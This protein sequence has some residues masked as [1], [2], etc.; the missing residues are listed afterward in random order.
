MGKDRA[1]SADDAGG[2]WPLFSRRLENREF[3]LFSFAP[4]VLTFVIRGG[5]KSAPRPSATRTH[6]GFGGTAD[7]SLLSYHIS[8]KKYEK[9]AKNIQKNKS[10]GPPPAV[11]I[12]YDE[13]QNERRK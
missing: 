1:P 12:L 8:Y 11:A 3:I 2:G 10:L 6:P 13:S 9:Y 5:P 7:D 4:F